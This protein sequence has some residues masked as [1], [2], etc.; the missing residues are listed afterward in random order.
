MIIKILGGGC[1]NCQ[2]LYKNTLEALKTLDLEA[3][4]LKVEDIS[5]IMSYGVMKTPALIIDDE[6]KIMGRVPKSKEL[7]KLLKSY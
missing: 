6:L 5:E 2:T 1:K 4:V 3:E 7:V